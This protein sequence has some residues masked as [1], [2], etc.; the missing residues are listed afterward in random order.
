M[1]LYEPVGCPHCRESGYVGRVAIAEYF[2]VDETIREMIEHGKS[3][4]EMQRYI[5]SSGG[6]DIKA[7]ALK[8]LLKGTTDLE[9][10]RRI[11]G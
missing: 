4:T 2:R 5:R 10:V 11:I 6:T 8:K 3:S 1:K 9:E 7:D